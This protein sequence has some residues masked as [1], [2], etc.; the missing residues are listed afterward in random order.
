MQWSDRIVGFTR[1]A[2]DQLLANPANARLHPG[3]QR[4]AMRGILDNVGWI[5]GVIQNDTTG[6]LIDGHLRV[7]EALSAGEESIPVLHVELDPY[8]EALVLAAFDPIAAMAKYDKERLDTLLEDIDCTD[9][10][11]TKMLEALNDTAP[12]IPETD[13]DLSIFGDDSDF[14]SLVLVYSQ[15]R[16][17][18]V[19]THLNDIE[20]KSP[21][22]KVW[23][24]IV[25]TGLTTD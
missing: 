20:G 18:E 10:R 3:P 13:E 1:E 11:L 23:N 9:T 22:E 15:D 19:M 21:A 4:D 7:E 14:R 6:M 5:T 16:Y 2:P 25:R 17:E 12:T 24:L 8:E